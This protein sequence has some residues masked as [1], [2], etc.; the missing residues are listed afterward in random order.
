MKKGREGHHPLAE[1]LAGVIL[2]FVL[3]A[4]FPLPFLI[5]ILQD[6]FIPLPTKRDTHRGSRKA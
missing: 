3:P 2:L 5:D 6:F 1:I 4:H